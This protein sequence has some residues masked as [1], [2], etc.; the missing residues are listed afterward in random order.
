VAAKKGYFNTSTLY[1]GVPKSLDLILA[2]VPADDDPS[3]ELVPPEGCVNCHPNQYLEW[4][5]SP[6]SAGGVNTWLHDIYSGT[7]TPG[8]MGGFVYTRDSAFA[9]K[10]PNSECSAC[11]QPESW[12]LEPFSAMEGPLDT[13]YPSPAAA[14]GISCDVCHK[15]AHVNVENINYPGLFPGALTF[16]RPAN[17]AQVLYGVLGDT[18]FEEAGVMRAS[19][20]P[21]LTAEVC[22]TCHQDKNDLHETGEFDGV[23]SEPTYLEW[24]A[25]PYGDVNS[26]L[27]ASCV[28]CHMLPS[29]AT[30]VCTILFPPLERDPQTIR[31]HNI[32]GTTPIY[33]ENAADVIVQAAVVDDQLEV[34]VD[35]YNG[36]TGHHVP[37]GV[38]VRNMILLVEAWSE[39]DG[40]PLA[41]LGTQVVHDLGGVPGP[42]KPP[43]EGYYAGLPGKFFAKVNHDA[44]G[45][46]PTF[47]TDATGIQF[48]SRIPALETDTTDYSFRMPAGGGPVRV[49]ARL[50]YRRAFR[51]LVDAKQWTEDGHGQPLGDV[52]PPHYG[53]LMELEEVV[54]GSFCAAD[55]AGGPNGAPDGNV[56]VFD[57]LA[58]IAQWGSC[59]AC[60]ADLTGPTAGVPDGNVDSLDFLLLIG[61]WGTPANCPSP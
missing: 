28:D 34:Q 37:T 55:L 8:G 2:P 14:H 5:G 20:Q 41:H 40:V 53:H 49:R 60:E 30:E 42:G 58:L 19:Y 61:Q 32:L 16:T 31:D 43:E 4:S 17:G 15:I 35:V 7:G 25:S 21:Q 59:G 9:G 24:A 10:N 22:G 1:D 45:A 33:L 57:F 18:D 56:D 47:F 23:I 48:D 51:F 44:S 39:R 46:G 29:G 3:Y 50:I 26:P 54:V 12:I 11:H 36:A 52:Q 13:D 6:M 27:Y 38:T